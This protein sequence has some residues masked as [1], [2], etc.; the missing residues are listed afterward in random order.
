LGK[1][2]LRVGEG[3]VMPTGGIKEWLWERWP[4]IR[5]V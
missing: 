1:E 5:C 3:G 4:E 2:L